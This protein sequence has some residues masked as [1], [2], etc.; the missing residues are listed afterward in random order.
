MS[1]DSG[2]PVY[3]RN[4]QTQ[5]SYI[6]I[7]GKEIDYNNLTTP[8]AFKERPDEAWGVIAYMI[9]IINQAK[10]HEG[11]SM[12][13]ELLY[14]KEYFVVTSNVDKQF[15]KAGFDGDSIY[16]IH[17]S[18]FYSQCTKHVDCGL[19]CTDDIDYDKKS[20]LAQYPYPVCPNCYSVCRPNVLLF[21]DDFFLDDIATQQH[22]RYMEWK[23]LV[24]NTCENIIALEIGAG[25]QVPAIR[26][27][28][29][30]LVGN[31]FPLFRINLTECQVHQKNHFSVQGN[32]LDIIQKVFNHSANI[33]SAAP[34]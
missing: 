1:A 9:D 6:E 15:H 32:A 33:Q 31:T 34:F 26:N 29:E 13:K 16:E 7:N 30:R 27:Y 17:G 25:T 23:E 21:D 3:R 8:Q 22:H 19:W 4:N 10:T 2:L 14:G 12:L 20:I 28:A 18:V 24:Y 5:K 11:Y